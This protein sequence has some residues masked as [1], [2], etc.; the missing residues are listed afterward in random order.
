MTLLNHAK[1]EAHLKLFILC[2]NDYIIT[3][4][5]TIVDFTIINNYS[6]L[7]WS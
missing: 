1:L 3:E 6:I 4:Y 2:T 7:V 5:D